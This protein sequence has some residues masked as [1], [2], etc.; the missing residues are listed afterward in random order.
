VL[1]FEEAL[2]SQQRARDCIGGT[3]LDRSWDVSI[4]PKNNSNGRYLTYKVKLVPSLPGTIQVYVSS[5]CRSRS[6]TDP[7]ITVEKFLF[8]VSYAIETLPFA[9]VVGRGVTFKVYVS[10]WMSM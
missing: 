5:S 10:F 6:V 3:S 4:T 7:D 2:Q 8:S 1:L 9:N